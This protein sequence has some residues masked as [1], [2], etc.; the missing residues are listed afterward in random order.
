MR[1][2]GSGPPLALELRPS[3]L[4]AGVYA[5]AWGGGAAAPLFSALP[6]GVAAGLA[7]AGLAGLAATLRRH[8]FNT[9]P[10]A[11]TALVWEA[12]G[13]WRLALGD[14]SRVAAHLLP[15]AY[16]HPRLTVLRFRAR[17]RRRAL[18]AVITPDRVDPEAFRRLRVRLYLWSQGHAPG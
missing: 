11:V 10:G 18:S 5:L 8:A 7:V 1:W 9:A 3:R 12:H 14:G 4:L 17:G 2:T 15:G 13:G 6:V 16:R